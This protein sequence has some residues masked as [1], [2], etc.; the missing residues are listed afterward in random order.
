M[1]LKYGMYISLVNLL[2]ILFMCYLF[3]IPS[4]NYYLLSLLLH[5]QQMRFI[6]G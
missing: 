6:V 3:W 2:K 4:L 1:K 5:T